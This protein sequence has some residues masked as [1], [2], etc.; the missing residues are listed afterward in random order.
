MSYVAFHNRSL[1]DPEAFWAA[2]SAR[3]HW[4]R[5]HDQVRD[6]HR[7]PSARWFVG[8]QTNLCFNAV[9]RWK[10]QSPDATALIYHSTE[11]GKSTQFTYATLYESVNGVARMLQSLGVGRGDRVMIYLPMVPEAVFAMLACA[12]I[13]AIHVVVF[14]GF[15]SASLAHRI[16][17]AK[18]LVIVTADAGL[19]AGKVI[20][21]Q[22]LLDAALAA[23]QHEPAA[24]VQLHRGLSNDMPSSRV[25]H[26]WTKTISTCGNAE[27]PVAWMESNDLS[28]ILYTSGTTGRPKGVVRDVGGYAVAMATSMEYIFGGRAGEVFFATSDIGWVVGHSYIVYG[29]L[30]S[31]MTTVL[32]EG[33]PT[34]ENAEVIWSLVERYRVA[35]LF[36][37]PTAMRVLKK[38]GDRP[39]A[40][41]DLSSLACLY[42]AGE[43]L[44][45]P[46]TAWLQSATKVRIC[47]NYWQT[48]TGWPI[49]ATTQDFPGASEPLPTKAGSPGFAMPG[50]D[51]RVIDEA[52]GSECGPGEKGVLTIRAPLPPGGMQTLWE[53]DDR[54]LSTYWRRQGPAG[55]WFY[56]TFDWGLKDQDGYHFILGRADDVIN[57]AGHR[58]GTREIEECLCGHSSVS[59]AAVVGVQDAIKGQ[60]AVA[61][62]VLRR[63]DG[64]TVTQL[65]RELSGRVDEQLGA[66]ARPA[67]MYVVPSLPKTR[68]GKVLRRVIQAICEG[69]APGDLSTLEDPTAIAGINEALAHSQNP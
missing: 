43:P 12:R 56:S 9:D 61:F 22:P 34:D 15:A 45:E 30:I 6:T 18:P 11:T 64:K 67:R 38:F 8:G 20:E 60:A 44:D 48:E 55:E 53:D 68:S 46:T 27:V 58:L 49:L 29:P 65:L 2:E 31:G 57:V 13:G 16:D 21:Y 4:S 35:R 50:F 24:V 37:S 63:L 5:P 51:V 33:L 3:I 10:E 59:E 47:D 42:L 66:I 39:I 23:A 17:D 62:V 1:E 54:Y 36:S 41:H 69:R 14:G 32:F 26:D 7:L 19:R 28:Y 25:T 52:T 40:A